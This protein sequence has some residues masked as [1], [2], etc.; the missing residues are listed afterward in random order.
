MRKELLASDSDNPDDAEGEEGIAEATMKPG[1]YVLV[2]FVTDQRSLK[3][4]VG[5]I[6]SQY[7][8]NLKFMRKVKGL[9]ASFAFPDTE[10][11]STISANSIIL[12]LGQPVTVAGTKRA[13]SKVM[14]HFITVNR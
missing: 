12:L 2:K 4:Y 6:L 7:L 13:A 5:L 14:F 11:V 8:M 1:K 9:A 10:D 3:Y